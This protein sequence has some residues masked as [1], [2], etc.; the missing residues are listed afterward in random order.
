MNQIIQPFEKKRNRKWQ[1]HKAESL[2][3][4][5]L[6]KRVAYDVCDKKHRKKYLNR[7]DSIKKCAS[8]IQLMECPNCEGH[9]HV[10]RAILCHDRLCPVCQWRRAMILSRRT[11]EALDRSPGQMIFL[12]LTIPSVADGELK[13]TIKKLTSGFG[14]MM[15]YARIQKSTLGAIRTLEVTKTEAGWHPHIHAI[16]KV[17]DDYFTSKKYI[18]HEEWLR[19]WRRA[20]RNEK[21]LILRVQK[22]YPGAER[23]LSKYTTSGD[24]LKDFTPEELF[25]YAEA[26]KGVRLWVS[27]G[28]LKINEENIDESVE[29][30]E[31]NEENYVV[32]PH[33]GVELIKI[34]YIF[35]FRR[36][37]YVESEFVYEWPEKKKRRKRGLK[38]DSSIIV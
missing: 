8:V 38:D 12:T 25:E 6:I 35:D 5:D 29:N 10:E 32:C 15:K 22:A 30:D 20:M 7:Y 24:T 34:D 9:A 18:K 26:I 13:K 21:I 31:K 11:R 16:I 33:C 28:I 17:P 37:K 19:L 1:E 4:L 3:I 23:E 36:K 27:S 14:K 2:P